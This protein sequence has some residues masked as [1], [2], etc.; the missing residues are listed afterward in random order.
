MSDQLLDRIGTRHIC[1]KAVEYSLFGRIISQTVFDKLR[2]C[3]RVHENIRD[4]GD[5]QFGLLGIQIVL[6]GQR[7]IRNQ[8]VTVGCGP[9][10]IRHVAGG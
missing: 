8:E 2:G 6:N 1:Q 4:V 5:V 7:L 3:V 9:A 10:V